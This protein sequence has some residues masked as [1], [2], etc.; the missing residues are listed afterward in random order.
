[1]GTRNLTCVFHEGNYKIAKYGQWDGY[2]D[3][4]GIDILNFLFKRFDKE[5]FIQNLNKVRFITDE[6]MKALWRSAGAD[7][8]GWATVE[9][10]DKFKDTNYSL[11]RDCSGDE[12]LSLVQ[13][14]EV[15]K[16][17]N[18]IDFAGSG[19]FCEW[20]YVIDLDKNTFEVYKGFNQTDLDPSERF[21][22]FERQEK[23]YSPV[24]HVKTYSLDDLPN[25]ETF[26]KN[27]NPPEE[28]TEDE[29]E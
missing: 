6:E 11:S 28:D 22:A 29:P 2:P 9:V 24:K 5:T 15:D 8:S 19:L 20:C 7:D 23:D 16:Q 10:S 14:G 18:S 3:S 4:L 27:T 26:L 1:M 13:R 21:A 12:L 25:E 17:S